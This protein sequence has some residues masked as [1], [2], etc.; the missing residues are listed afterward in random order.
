MA[1]RRPSSSSP[2]TPRRSRY[3]V[4]KRGAR[5]WCAAAARDRVDVAEQIATGQDATL[6]PPFD[7]PWIIAGQGTVGLE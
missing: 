1:F 3:T 4:P 5:R 7:H 6:V 2:T